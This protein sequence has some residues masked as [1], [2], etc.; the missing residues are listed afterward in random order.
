MPVTAAVHV[1]VCVVMMDDGDAE[2]V[3]DVIVGAAVTVIVAEPDLVGSWFDVAVQD[4]VP[5]PDGVNTPEELIVP[6]VAVQVTPELN[7]PVPETVAEHVA[8]CKVVIDEGDAET[9]TDVMV[10]AGAVTVI[11]VEPDLVGSWVDVA[12]Q[13]AEP[14]PDGVKRPEELIDPPVAVQVTPEPE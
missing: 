5:A 2:T 10:E 3:T 9:M 7:D 8:V 14:A 6:P 12:V 4:A 13:E 11:V 1:A